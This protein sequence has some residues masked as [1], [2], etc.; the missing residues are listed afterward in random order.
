LEAAAEDPVGEVSKDSSTGKE[1]FKVR[2]LLDDPRN[3]QSVLDFL[4]TTD[5]ERRASPPAEE[6]ESDLSEVKLRE[7]RERDE[8]KRG[9]AE[10]LGAEAEEP[11][12][13]LTSAFMASAHEGC[14]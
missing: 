8:E 1:R 10:E 7:R 9:E 2:D 6:A 11:L 5:V 14:E 13:H 4:S 12:I 3:S